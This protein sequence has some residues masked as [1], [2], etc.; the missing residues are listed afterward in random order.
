MHKLRAHSDCA[1]IRAQA[2]VGCGRSV[3]RA[4][5]RLCIVLRAPTRVGAR[6]MRCAYLNCGRSFIVYT[7]IC[8]QLGIGRKDELYYIATILQT[9]Q[10]THLAKTIITL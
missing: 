3:Y 7:N 8:N 10:Q 4:R 6:I 9:M 1:R 5:V 2:D